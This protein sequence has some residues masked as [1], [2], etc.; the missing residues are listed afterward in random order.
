MQEPLLYNRINPLFD[1]L[2]IVFFIFGL[3]ED[4]IARYKMN[5]VNRNIRDH[6]RNVVPNPKTSLQIKSQ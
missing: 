2:F 3:C 1:S 5:C 4:E 6:E